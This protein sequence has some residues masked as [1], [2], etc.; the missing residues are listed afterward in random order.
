[1]TLLINLFGAPGAGKSTTRAGVFR[2]L[3]LARVKVEE[4][5]EVAKDWTWE[6]RHRSLQFAPYLFGKQLRN[7]ERLWGKVDVIV[8]DSPPI[9]TSFYCDQYNLDYPFEF[10]VLTRAMHFRLSPSINYL[11]TRVK[12]YVEAGRNQTEEESD[13]IA[14]SLKEW[15]RGAGVFCKTIDGDEHADDKIFHH[16]MGIDNTNERTYKECA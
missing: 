2:R 3:K 9:L 4:V 14:V 6:E 1:M 5:P 13:T 8:T 11:I 7:I 10:H 12:P 16:A 15:L